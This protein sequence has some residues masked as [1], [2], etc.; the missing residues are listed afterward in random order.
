MDNCQ[1]CFPPCPNNACQS[2]IVTLPCDP[3]S[4]ELWFKYKMPA[5]LDPVL[6]NIYNG[7]W[8]CNYEPMQSVNNKMCQ[9]NFSDIG[10]HQ[11]YNTAYQVDMDSVLKNI[12]N[13]VIND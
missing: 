9:R 13:C 10:G 6:S 2:K 7:C 1:N 5:D 12:N 8:M 4:K 3:N 11:P